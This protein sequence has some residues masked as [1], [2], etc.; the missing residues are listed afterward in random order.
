MTGREVDGGREGRARL[1]GESAYVGDDGSEGED[2]A[3]GVGA[4][5]G[6]H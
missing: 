1:D 6:G 4:E 5:V 3:S 2:F